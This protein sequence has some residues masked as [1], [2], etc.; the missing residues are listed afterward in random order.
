MA[1]QGGM[2]LLQLMDNYAVSGITLFFVVF[3]QAVALIWIYGSNNISDHIKEM[4][5]RWPNTPFSNERR[6]I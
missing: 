1:T 3:F 6:S 5:G 2:Y 4:I